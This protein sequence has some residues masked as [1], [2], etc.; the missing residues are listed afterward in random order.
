MFDIRGQNISIPCCIHKGSRRES[1]DVGRNGGGGG[2]E[3]V[4]QLVE[5]R[6]GTPPVQVPFPGEARDFLVPESTFGAD[7]LKVSVHPPPPSCNSKHLHLCAR[8]RSRSPCQSSV[9]CGDTKTPNNQ[10]AP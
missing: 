7:F 1:P 6:T 5:H 9:D 8:Y 2:G 4:A 3:D 10:H